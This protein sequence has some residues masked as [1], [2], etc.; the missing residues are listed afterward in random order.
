[1]L[2]KNHKPKMNE[3]IINIETDMKGNLTFKDSV[4]LKISGKF[5]GELEAKGVLIIGESADVKVTMIKG[6]NVTVLGK[7]KGNIVC[8][9]RLEICP[10]AQVI[11][12][13]RAA[14]LVIKEGAMLKGRC[15]V[16][17]P[18]E[19]HQPKQRVRRKR[20]KAE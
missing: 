15:H 19:D 12:D 2:N 18:D 5:E 8:S 14:V 13:I 11:G 9:A 7:I 10:P 20:N 1:M 3:Q 6:E 17:S 16:C 4:S